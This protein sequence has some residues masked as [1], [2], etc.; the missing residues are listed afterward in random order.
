MTASTGRPK[1]KARSALDGVPSCSPITPSTRIRSASIAARC[2][3]AAQCT[4]PPIHRSSCCTGEP[5]PRSSTIG[6]R[7]S[8]PVLN[9][10]T[11]RPWLRCQCASAAVT[12]VLPWPEAGAA[13]SSAGQSMPSPSGWSV[14]RRFID[15][16]PTRPVRFRLQSA[17]VSKGVGK[18]NGCAACRRPQDLHRPPQRQLERSRP[19]S[20]LT[21]PE[22]FLCRNLPA[23]CGAFPGDDHPVAALPLAP[24]RPLRGQ[25][26]LGLDLE[27]LD[28][29][30]SRLTRPS[31]EGRA[32][33]AG[34]QS[35]S[36]DQV[37]APFTTLAAVGRCP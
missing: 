36:A 26:R 14:T 37:T 10:R 15:R 9:T 6:S 23:A 35:S 28:A 21:S 19:V 29:P 17:G 7:K 32:P 16:P 1:C 11:R 5:L 34:W 33:V 2:S 13:T 27:G 20:G 8:G 30:A 3:S 31:C 4:G 22:P 12:V 25:R 18:S 24:R